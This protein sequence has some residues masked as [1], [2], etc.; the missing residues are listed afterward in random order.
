MNI[1]Y[2]PRGFPYAAFVDAYGQ[3]CSI[4]DSSKVE[5]DMRLGVDKSKEPGSTGRMH[6]TQDQ[7]AALVV[8][9]QR[10]V[11]TGSIAENQGD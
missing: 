10:F 5:P 6:L 4:Q 1:E 8:L 7:A 11:A 2:T 3:E 9:L